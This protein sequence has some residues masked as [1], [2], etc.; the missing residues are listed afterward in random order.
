MREGRFS[1]KSPGK[2]VP[3]VL[4][5][6]RTTSVG[7][8]EVDP[9]PSIAFV[10]DK[11]PPK[12]DWRLI[13]GELF[14]HFEAATAALMRINGLVPLAPN[15]KILRQAL[16]LRE[17]KISSEIED[18]HTN[19]LEMVMAGSGNQMLNSGRGDRG[20]EAWNAMMAVRKGLESD[21]PFSGRLIKEMHQVLL[22]GTRG[23]EKMPG[24][25]RVSQAYIGPENKPE[26][27]RFVP[28]PPGDM[29]G[30]VT[31]CMGQI[32][33]FVNTEW[34]EIPRLAQVAM[35]HYQ[36]ET[37]HPFSDGNGRIGRA[38]II[39]QLC[40]KGLLDLPVVFVSGYLKRY[41]QEYVDRL[42]AVSADG[43][44]IGWI[45]FF[46]DAVATQAAQTRVLAER[47][48]RMHREYTERLRQDG[49]PS[50]L[51]ILIDHLFDWPV[52]TAKSVAQL[53]GVSDP[54][55]RKDISLFEELGIL[56]VT[57]DVSWGRA[58]FVPAIIAVIDATD[59]DIE[60]GAGNDL[61]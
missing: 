16:W 37:I 46:V 36:F 13:K 57:E 5:R 40:R 11:L 12:I 25:Y 4:G 39:H 14:D 19:A 32:E 3:T 18:I 55:A 52:V 48:I 43:D 21:L 29:P 15:T 8:I 2:L 50:R 6:Q 17:A 59:E 10:P 51:F 24:E 61:S 31:A 30:G 1:K 44:W 47:L 20:L 45:R 23:E 49:V 27:A 35:M 56:R 34:D 22:V 33:R 58:W 9:V 53:L 7:L 60:S 42:F 28:P 54:T 38:L 26:K 41:Q